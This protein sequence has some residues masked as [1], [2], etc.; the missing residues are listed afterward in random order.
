MAQHRS[1][2]L[3]VRT[4]VAGPSQLFDT[5]GLIASTRIQSSH[6]PRGLL[7]CCLGAQTCDGGNSA[8]HSSTEEGRGEGGGGGGRVVVGGGVEGGG[9]THKSVAGMQCGGV[10]CC[11]ASPDSL[12]SGLSPLPPPLPPPHHPL[13]PSPTGD[14][15]YHPVCVGVSVCWCVGT[16]VTSCLCLLTVTGFLPPYL[17]TY[18]LSAFLA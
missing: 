10:L 13:P 17:P 5:S 14:L 4:T 11:M 2:G 8:C 18:L 12:L 6:T 7:Y 9:G 3:K 15:S 16:P 1:T